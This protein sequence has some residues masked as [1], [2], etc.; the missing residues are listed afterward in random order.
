MDIA[1]NVRLTVQN[2]YIRLYNR[3][4]IDIDISVSIV[5]YAY[6]DTLIDLLT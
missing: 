5:L 1:Y 6:R 2:I 3:Y 4:N